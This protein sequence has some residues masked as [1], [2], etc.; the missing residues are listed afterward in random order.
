MQIQL[1]NSL[2]QTVWQKTSDG[3]AGLNV[4]NFQAPVVPSG[5]Y[6]L[7]VSKK[8]DRLVSTIVVK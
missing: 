6:Q 8:A 1:V 3:D 7:V 4:L 5:V 2:G